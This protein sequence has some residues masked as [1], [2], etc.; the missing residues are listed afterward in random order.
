M[1]R[2]TLAPEQSSEKRNGRKYG[3]RPSHPIYVW[4]GIL[5]SKHRK[6]IGPALWEFLW[7]LDRITKEKE[8]VGIVLGGKPVIYAEIAE[9]FGVSE[10]TVQRH[11]ERLSRQGYIAGILTPRG[12]SIRVPNSCKFRKQI[13][14]K[15]PTTTADQ[16]EGSHDATKEELRTRVS[17]QVGQKCPTAQDRSD[18]APDK[19]VLANIRESSLSN[20]LEEAGEKATAARTAPLAPPSPPIMKN[21]TATPTPSEEETVTPIPTFIAPLAKRKSIP[22]EQNQRELDERR[23]LLLR[24]REEVLAR[25][26]G[27]GNSPKKAAATVN[28]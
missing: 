13:G 6:K 7:C 11:M 3:D 27:N 1:A 9:D 16:P 17:T 28:P 21:E 23:R 22:R 14:Q 19:S 10:K 8:G 20:Q 5:E 25:F 18:P 26:P 12:Y 4:N 2:I 24:Q 15:C